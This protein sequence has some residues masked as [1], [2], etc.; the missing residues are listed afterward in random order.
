MTVTRTLTTGG[1]VLRWKDGASEVYVDLG[2]DEEYYYEIQ[3]I[4][5]IGNCVFL[6]VLRY[7]YEDGSYRAVYY[8]IFDGV[9]YETTAKR[10]S[11]N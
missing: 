2:N 4:M 3:E 8:Y 11:P 7:N 5:P 6:Y 10:Q 1:Q 9:P